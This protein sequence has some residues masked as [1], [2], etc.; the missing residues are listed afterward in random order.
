MAGHNKWSKI[1]HKKGANDAKRAKVWTKI[2]RE[3]TI[4]AKMGGADPD[5]NPRLRKAIDDAKAANMPK[6]TV[7]RAVNKGAGGDDD[8][9]YEELVY[10]GYGPAGVALYVECATDNR[11]R[12]SADIRAAFKKRGGNLGASGSVAYMFDKKG[13][14]VFEKAPDDGAAPTE[15]ALLEVGMDHGAEDVVD[16]GEAFEVTC[17][18]NDFQGLREAFAAA[19]FVPALAKVAMIPQNM[20]KTSGDDAAQLLKLVDALEDLDDVQ[21]VW[22][23]FDID[24]EELE[25][26][27]G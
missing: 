4:A 21:N 17:E 14:F 15:D 7:Q 6:D 23:N 2:I 9:N 10:E 5:G 13:Q 1:K 22:G 24:P 3:V 19:G 11:N 25:K 18:S 16:D 26:L 20:V 8:A 12:T 27:L